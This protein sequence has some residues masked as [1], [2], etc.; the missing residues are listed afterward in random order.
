MQ[1]NKPFGTVEVRV[2]NY[3]INCLNRVIKAASKAVD[4]RLPP[5]ENELRAD[6]NLEKVEIIFSEGSITP[7]RHFF[8]NLLVS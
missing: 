8:P 2:S 3:D 5:E 7:E 4:H 6:I 1:K